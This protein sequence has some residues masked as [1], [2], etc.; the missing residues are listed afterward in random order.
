MFAAGAAAAGLGACG[1]ADSGPGRCAATRDAVVATSDYTSSGLGALSLDGGSA[2]GFAVD[3]GKDPSLAESRGRIFFV[4]RDLD[5]IFEVDRS[6][7]TPTR[8]LSVHGAGDRGAVNPQ[9]VAVAP[10]GAL[11]IPLYNAPAIAVLRGEAMDRVDLSALD[12]DGNPQASSTRIVD[13]GGA[14]KAFVALEMLDADFKS[15]R[16]SKMARF[17][18]A[19]R[20]LEATRDLAG[21]NPFGPMVEADGAFFIAAPGNFDAL[22]E[23][24]AGVERFDPAT[25]TGSLLVSERDLGG[26]AVEVAVQGACGAAIVADASS[27]NATALVTFDAKSGRVLAPAARP[28]ARTDDFDLRGLAWRDGALLVGDRRRAAA[29]FPVRVFERSAACELR[30][31]PDSVP[32]SQKPIAIR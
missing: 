4:A 15:R 20:A 13:V 31:R 11:W 16:A 21:R 19:T 1:T 7:G 25:F 9:D 29:G 6:C 12:G 10:D 17:D 32:I 23:P 3:L 8:R 22:D 14:P 26:S 18:V 27:K 30:E 5:S 28:V 2:L 24:D